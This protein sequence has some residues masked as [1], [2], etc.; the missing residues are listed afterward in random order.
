MDIHVDRS[1]GLFGYE[2]AQGSKGIVE[3]RG[4]V[5]A[6]HEAQG[7]G[8]VLGYRETRT[9]SFV[10]GI[11]QNLTFHIEKGRW[12]DLYFSPTGDKAFLHFFQDL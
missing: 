2:K 12:G 9:E 1:G 8:L 6:L 10:L 5:T 11:G 4:N 7:I 3:S